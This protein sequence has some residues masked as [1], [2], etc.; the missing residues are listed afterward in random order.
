MDACPAPLHSPAKLL[1]GSDTPLLHR[2]LE[3]T[4]P[5]CKTRRRTK[6]NHSTRA[7]V[8]SPRLTH[9]GKKVDRLQLSTK[10]NASES[11]PV[12]VRPNTSHS[13]HTTAEAADYSST[14][15]PTTYNDD[16]NVTD[17]AIIR[18]DTSR[19]RKISKSKQKF[20]HDPQRE[21]LKT[22]DANRQFLSTQASQACSSNMLQPLA[23]PMPALSRVSHRTSTAEQLDDQDP[24]ALDELFTDLAKA[25]KSESFSRITVL[26]R[27]SA[28]HR[29]QHQP[30][31]KVKTS[32]RNAPSASHSASTVRKVPALKSTSKTCNMHPDD[33]EMDLDYLI[34]NIA[35]LTSRSGH[36]LIKAN[37]V[38]Q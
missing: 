38:P 4:E 30:R 21:V 9:K 8:S 23:K 12:A 34:T 25:K 18:Q 33:D 2:P 5:A 26:A 14:T 22:V 13:G 3:S 15:G 32:D 11:N 28:K 17:E 29:Q 1:Q 16:L 31:L 6:A 19:T 37:E 35:D 20:E 24:L 10:A 7:Q 36:T 27:P